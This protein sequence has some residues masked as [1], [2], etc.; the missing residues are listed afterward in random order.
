MFWRHL[1][2]AQMVD[3]SY[4]TAVSGNPIIAA[5]GWITSELTTGTAHQV[6]PRAKIG[7]GNH[8]LA[9]GTLGINYYQ[10]TGIECMGVDGAFDGCGPSS[11]GMRFALTP[12]EAQSIDGKLDD[13]LPLAGNVRALRGDQDLNFLASAGSPCVTAASRYD[14]GSTNGNTPNCQLRIRMN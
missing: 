14:I 6:F 5:T 3:G 8:V 13:G 9:Y 2:E 4:A 7:R 12:I 1:T 11:I 10:L